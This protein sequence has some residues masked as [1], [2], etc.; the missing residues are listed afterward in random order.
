MESSAGL[1]GVAVTVEEDEVVERPTLFKLE[2]EAA[3][4]IE[5]FGFEDCFE[6]P[7]GPCLRNNDF[8]LIIAHQ[9]EN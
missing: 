4:R 9:A 1:D 2:V 8:N 3:P 5:L 6:D 7:D